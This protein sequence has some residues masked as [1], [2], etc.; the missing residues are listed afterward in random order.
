L[1]G[2]RAGD[3]S[4]CTTVAIRALRSFSIAAD[5]IDLA[6]LDQIRHA[7]QRCPGLRFKIASRPL[8]LDTHEHVTRHPVLVRWELATACS[9]ERLA[10]DDPAKLATIAYG[11]L[12]HR[13]S[14]D[15]LNDRPRL[16]L[17]CRPHRRVAGTLSMAGA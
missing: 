14:E 6:L 9:D 12:H 17:S 1:F 7:S 4:T 16:R 10:K 5:A 15:G 3:Y 2:Q 11:L 13:S 8:I